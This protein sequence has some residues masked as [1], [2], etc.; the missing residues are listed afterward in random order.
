MRRIRHL[1]AFYRK[2]V[3]RNPA[4]GRH[5]GCQHA[6][7]LVPMTDRIGR[8]AEA[9]SFG[10]YVPS[11]RPPYVQADWNVEQSVARVRGGESEP[12][13]LLRLRLH[14]WKL[15]RERSST[16]TPQLSPKFSANVLSAYLTQQMETTSQYRRADETLRFLEAS[17]LPQPT[18]S[19][20]GAVF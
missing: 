15:G 3:M 5:E 19:W 1:Y 6:Q 18:S 8:S 7:Q 4:A 10:S 16:S 17:S 13:M 2:L 11:Q 20:K 12:G 14:R 9:L